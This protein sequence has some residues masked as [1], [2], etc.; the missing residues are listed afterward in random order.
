[1]RTEAYN[2]VK[3]KVRGFYRCEGCKKTFKRENLAVDHTDPVVD[4]DKGFE[5]YDKYIERM[6]CNSSELKVLCKD[7]CHKRKTDEEN[8][9]RKEA[10]S[11]SKRK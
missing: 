8:Q 10:R 1:M 4:P 6:F 5:G 11:R 7:K 2:N 3:T 9:R